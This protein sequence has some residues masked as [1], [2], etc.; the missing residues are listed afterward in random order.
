MRSTL[1]SSLSGLR[2][3]IGVRAP[4]SPGSAAAIGGAMKDQVIAS[5]K[6]APMSTSLML[7]SNGVSA[8]TP[9]TAVRRP[10]SVLG[11]RS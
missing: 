11:T 4:P 7:S 10:G 3:G 6:P 9:V 2:S 8:A 5:S 1:H